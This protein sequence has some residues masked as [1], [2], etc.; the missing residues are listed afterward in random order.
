MS[1]L[2]KRIDNLFTKLR[3]D[4]KSILFARGDDINEK[5]IKRLSGSRYEKDNILINFIKNS[6]KKVVR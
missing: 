4:E 5:T 2:K 6:K 1:D 3:L